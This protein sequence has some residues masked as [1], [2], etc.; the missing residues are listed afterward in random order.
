MPKLVKADAIIQR[1]SLCIITDEAGHETFKS[2]GFFTIAGVIGFTPEILRAGLQWN[3]MKER[4]FGGADQPVHASGPMMSRVQIDAIS[5]FFE[6][7][8]LARFAYIIKQPPVLLP[9]LN[10]VNILRPMLLD[11]VVKVIG[12]M[13][14]LPEDIMFAMEYSERLAPIITEFFPFALLECT[15]E[16]GQEISIQIQKVLTPKKPPNPHLEMADHVAWRAQRQYKV[17]NPNGTL[18]DEF[19]SVFPEGAKHAQYRENRIGQISR[20][21][22][23]KLVLDFDEYGRTK[24]TLCGSKAIP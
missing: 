8:H 21:D 1:R 20:G 7:S 18:M 2:E 15:D 17:H 9:E 10:A 5:H 6:K 24:I 22:D 23:P 4:H 3:R 19:I 11:D 13:E 14:I 12:N 16:S